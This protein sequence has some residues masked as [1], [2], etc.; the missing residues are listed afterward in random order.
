LASSLPA[1]EP[2]VQLALGMAKLALLALH[3]PTRLLNS[4]VS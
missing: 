3:A 4:Q 2:Q 1:L